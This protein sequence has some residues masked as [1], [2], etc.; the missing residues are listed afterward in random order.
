MVNMLLSG[1]ADPL[2]ANHKGLTP[3]HHAAARCNTDMVDL[4]FAA[5]P[6]ALNLGSHRHGQTPLG[7]VVETGVVPSLRDRER[8]VRHLLSLGAN[9]KSVPRKEGN[10]LVKAAGEGS[11]VVSIYQ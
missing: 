9:E 5:A 2:L 4:I 10:A 8:I 7:L 1:G 11:E 3:M 6:A